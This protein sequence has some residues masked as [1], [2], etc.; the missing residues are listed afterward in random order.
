M[1]RILIYEAEARYRIMLRFILEGINHDVAEAADWDDVPLAVARE[2]PDLLVLGVHLD[3]G[4]GHPTWPEWPRPTP[5]TPTLMLFSGDPDLR[6]TFLL[7]WGARKVSHLVQ[8]VEPYPLLKMVKAMLT[9][10]VEWR[11]GGQHALD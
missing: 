1:A 6:I 11:V 9:A 3:E 2:Q 8:P 7:E 10:P 5:E 4:P